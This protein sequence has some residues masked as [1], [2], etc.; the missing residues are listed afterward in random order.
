MFLTQLTICFIVSSFTIAIIMCIKKV[1]RNQLS[2]KWQYNIWFLLL[3]AMLLPFIP[4]HVINFSENFISL[5]WDYHEEISTTPINSG[6]ELLQGNQNWIKDFTISVNR[7]TSETLNMLIGSIWIVGIFVSTI[8][9]SIAWFHL[10]KIK[11][12][13]SVLNNKEYIKI[14]EQSKQVLNISEH[15]IVGE[16]S[17]IKS[18]MTFGLF[19]TYVVL[20]SH[21]DK[22][23]TKEDIYHI[24]LHELNHYKCKDI[25]SNYCI[26][27]FQILYWFNPLVWYAFREMRLDRE[28]ACDI[29]VLK[30]VNHVQYLDYGKTILH[31]IDISSKQKSIKFVTELNG[32]KK[33]LKKR[34][35]KIAS[36]KAEPTILQLKS[37]VIF[38]LVGALVLSQIP[39]ISAMTADESHYHFENNRTEYIDL[40]D[41]F[42]GYNGSFVLYDSQAKQYKIYNKELSTT[43]IS[44]D[45]T[46]KIYSALL[47]LETNVISSDN[48]FIEWDGTK[49]SYDAWNQDQDLSTAMANSVNW[50]FQTI[51]SEV[52]INTIQAFIERINYGN[53]NLSSDNEPYWLESSLKISPVEQV[54]LLDAFYYNRFGFNEGNIQT[55]KSA[56]KLEEKG[57]ASLYGKTGTG[58]VNGKDIN[59]WFIGFVETKNNTYFF[60]TNIQRDHSTFG[61]KAADITLSILNDFGIYK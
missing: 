10:R 49:Y 52:P 21:F 53:Q 39:F 41:Y 43:R 26:V 42:T 25:V 34:I 29:A 11:R 14:F 27:F 31:F 50:Y 33:Q 48:T 2:A 40:K 1:F 35:E 4:S 3:I 32:S 44:P 20:P 15:L 30:S 55:V 24:F 59:G 51:D 5:D 37:I 47:G 60:A 45:S 57:E 13:V 19:K 61:S 58:N 12:S 6:D 16:S 28:I 22:Y 17:L 36:F 8:L 38:L 18:P 23:L 46:Y 9:V 7:R 54:K 56:I